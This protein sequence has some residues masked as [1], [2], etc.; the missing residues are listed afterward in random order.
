MTME[1]LTG[2]LNYPVSQIIIETFHIQV[3][4]P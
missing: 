3:I 4:S 2:F 1:E